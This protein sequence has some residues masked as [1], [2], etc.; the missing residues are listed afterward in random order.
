MSGYIKHFDNVRKNMPFVIKDDN[1]LIKY[2]EIPNKINRKLGMKFRSKPVYHAKYIKAKVKT[3]NGMS[4]SYL[5][6]LPA[7]A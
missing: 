4:W 5:V 2:N 6:H 1:V 7:R 3:F